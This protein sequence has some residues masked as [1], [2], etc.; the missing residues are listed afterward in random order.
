MS[1]FSVNYIYITASYLSRN[2]RSFLSILSNF[3]LFFCFTA[4][5]RQTLY[6]LLHHICLTTSITSYIFRSQFFILF[7]LRR[8]Y[9]LS[10]INYLKILY[11]LK[12]YCQKA[13]KQKVDLHTVKGKK[14][15]RLVKNE[16]SFSNNWNRGQEKRKSTPILT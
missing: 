6:H 12:F 14:M 11:Q 9:F 10:Q 16:L 8:P 3:R 13:E 1:R 4:H 7:G 15:V 2:W 5:Q